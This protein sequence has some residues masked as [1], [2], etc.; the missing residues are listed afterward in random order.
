LGQKKENSDEL[1]VWGNAVSAELIP[2]DEYL[3]NI[4]F[5]A[6]C[7]GVGL[8]RYSANKQPARE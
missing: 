7:P 8:A 6:V 3:L 2:N 4:T 5:N 1:T